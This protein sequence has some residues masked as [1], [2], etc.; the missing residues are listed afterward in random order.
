[1]TGAL[2]LR[3]G[4]PPVQ[5]IVQPSRWW[6]TESLTAQTI[7]AMCAGIQ[8]SAAD[9]Y[10]Q[11]AARAIPP[12][13]LG[14]ARLAPAVMLQHLGRA[15]RE[16]AAVA[17]ADWWFT[18]HLIRFVQDDAILRRTL[19]KADG[20]EALIDPAV[21]LRCE[22][23]EGDCDDFTGF[24][25]ALFTCQGLRWDIVTLACSPRQPGVWS[26]VF[27]RVHLSD[28]FAMPMDAS[29]GKFPGWSVPARDI[30]RMQIWDSAGDPVSDTSEEE[31]I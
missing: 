21:M 5:A 22:R 10:F 19:N 30:Q 29:H 27:P 6:D 2:Q 4:S 23:P 14:A 1:M 15:S 20:L 24:L 18:K 13:W 11:G 26:H 17:I 12:R 8:R 31:V 16:R 3:P 9:T 25:C 7:K 28:T